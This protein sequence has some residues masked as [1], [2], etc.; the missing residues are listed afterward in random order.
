LLRCT[1]T[2][3]DERTGSPVFGDNG[4]TVKTFNEKQVDFIE[5]HPPKA[6]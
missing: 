2:V 1:R 3:A 6:K 5:S 4:L